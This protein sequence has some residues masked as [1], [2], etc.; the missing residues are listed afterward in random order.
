MENTSLQRVVVIGRKSKT[1]P[2]TGE[3]HD[4]INDKKKTFVKGAERDRVD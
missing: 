2:D 3:T 1:L 4:D